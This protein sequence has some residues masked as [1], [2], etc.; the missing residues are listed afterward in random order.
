[1]TSASRVL[2]LHVNK[3]LLIDITT[4]VPLIANVVI[5]TIT[6][7]LPVINESAPIHQVKSL[8]Q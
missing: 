7:N 6:I 2:A 1:M 5:A 4:H 8:S 3:N